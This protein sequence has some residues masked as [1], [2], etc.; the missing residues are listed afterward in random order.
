[1]CY[2]CRMGPG[3]LSGWFRS[4]S[5]VFIL[6]PPVFPTS[7]VLKEMRKRKQ[8]EALGRKMHR[9]SRL[10]RGQLSKPVFQE[11]RAFLSAGF[12]HL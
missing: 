11:A 1:M 9:W 6:S 5:K 12:P 4:P 7:W 3:W 2:G 10:A 8:L